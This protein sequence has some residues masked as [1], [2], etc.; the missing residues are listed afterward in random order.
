MPC[1]R[2]STTCLADDRSLRYI[3]DTSCAA[4]DVEG[5]DM[6]IAPASHACRHPGRLL[7][8]LAAILAALTVGACAIPTGPTTVRSTPTP[9]DSCATARASDPVLTSGNVTVRPLYAEVLQYVN[10][11]TTHPVSDWF[12]LWSTDVHGT[13]GLPSGFFA[14][15]AD[16][17]LMGSMTAQD[18][19]CIV[20]DME[21]ADVGGVALRAAQQDT[22]LLSGPPTTVY[23]LPFRWGIPFPE[24]NIIVGY[25]DSN[26]VLLTLWEP[27]SP[28]SR[29]DAASI[30]A[31]WA[32][33][34]PD[35]TA[36]ECFEV[37]RYARIGVGPAYVNLLANMVT[38]GM[39][40]SFAIAQTDISHL[41]DNNLTPQEEQNI[42]GVI[43][44]HLLDQSEQD[45]VMFGSPQQ[46]Y[47]PDTGYTIGFH[48]VQGYL[49]RHPDVS[50]PALAGMS[51]DT[52]FAGSG[53]NG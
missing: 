50:F 24:L 10:D 23:I 9:Q 13:S 1:S 28:S 6:V 5:A 46:G 53:Y 8:G 39:A 49:A 15:P 43:Q 34:I 26:V 33:Y 38:D 45:A 51:T 16:D 2:S 40:D 35:M 4:G 3:L 29:Q 12:S 30:G 27:S 52:V 14:N 20:A 25:S 32:R 7:T 42:W 36:H 18:L 44:P 11:A 41:W 21:R 31:D 17:R 37:A 47:P 48:I 19:H 22:A